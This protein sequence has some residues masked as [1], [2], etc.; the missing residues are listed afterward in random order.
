MLFLLQIVPYS[1]TN[2][3]VWEHFYI[4]PIF[5]YKSKHRGMKKPRFHQGGF[6]FTE[7]AFAE[8]R[9]AVSNTVWGKRLT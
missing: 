3:A 7:P 2:E 1:D 6:G 8:Q 4:T 5:T 9:E